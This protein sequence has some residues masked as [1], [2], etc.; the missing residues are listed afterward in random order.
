MQL[1]GYAD[2]DAQRRLSVADDNDSDHTTEDR[3]LVVVLRGSCQPPRLEL[4][5]WNQAG[6]EE[7]EDA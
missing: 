7:W 2:G 4:R 5:G 6:M 3:E 1:R